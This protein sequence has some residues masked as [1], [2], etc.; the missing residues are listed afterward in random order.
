MRTFS[1]RQKKVFFGCFL[2]YACT[3]VARLNLAAA[4]PALMQSLSLTEAE[5]G[6]LQTAFAIVYAAGQL[7]NGAIADRVNARRHILTGLLLSAVCNL[8]FGVSGA[9]WQLLLLWA[10]NGAAQ[11]MLWTPIV[12]LMAGWFDAQQR[13]F[14]SFWIS[15]TLV[16]GHFVAWAIS[17][18]MAQLFS[19]RLSFIL[20][21]AVLMGAAWLAAAWLR[22]PEGKQGTAAGGVRKPKAM[23]LA[24]MLFSTGLW[25]VLICGVASGYVRDG[26]MTWGPAI[27]NGQGAEGTGLSATGLSLII[28]VL[29]LLGVLLGQA[30]LRKSR[31]KTRRIVGMLMGVG[32]VFS[33][34]L[35]LFSGGSLWAYALLLGVNCALMYGVNPLLTVILPMEY[36]EHGRVGLAAG[37]IDSLIYVGSAVTGVT[38]GLLQESYGLSVVFG[39]WA[40]AALLGMAA[41]FGSGRAF[42][43]FAAIEPGA[44]SVPPQC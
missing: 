30:M 26:V 12:K 9:Y 13:K 33:L 32:A 16:L 42:T 28:P 40:A 18:F 11:S 8:L 4:L 1:D 10:L 19:W 14:V 20:P 29:N 38:A 35:A 43:R 44:E 17:G 3:Y 37:M 2:V 24:Q 39:T 23:P 22:E 31:G 27:L 7:L 25:L 36:A 34:A 21:C 5:G 41:M 15:I 6:L